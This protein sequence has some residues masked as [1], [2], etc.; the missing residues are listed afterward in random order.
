MTKL[1][2]FWLDL[3]EGSECHKI[4]T[5][6]LAVMTLFSKAMSKISGSTLT[7]TLSM[8][9]HIDRMSRSVDLVIRR[10]SSIRHLPTTKTTA[11]LICSF[12]LSTA[13]L[14]SLT[15]TVIRCT[16]FKKFKITQRSFFF[17]FFFFFARADMK[18]LDHCSKHFTGCQLKKG[19]FSR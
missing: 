10:I 13:T 14:F 1:K 19:L 17:F 15:S 16:G 7:L 12:V 11:Q 3:V 18:T 4:T 9:K 8:V 2:L 5:W 6:E